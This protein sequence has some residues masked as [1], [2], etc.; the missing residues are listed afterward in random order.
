MYL[1]LLAHC[2]FFLNAY[3][4]SQ[5]AGEEVMLHSCMLHHCF[6]LWDH[7]LFW[8]IILCM[9]PIWSHCFSVL[10]SFLWLS[11]LFVTDPFCYLGFSVSYFKFSLTS[12]C[13]WSPSYSHTAHSNSL[14][15]FISARGDNPPKTE[16]SSTA[17][18]SS[19]GTI[20]II[21]TDGKYF[22]FIV[23]SLNVQSSCQLAIYYYF[24][25]STDL[26]KLI[27]YFR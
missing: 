17:S 9:F 23:L 25:H 7:D 6:H 21:S 18:L 5:S 4:A 20:T 1:L 26:N 27:F 13:Q 15:R 19:P 8:P 10:P 12:A 3:I 16:S 11:L 22:A 24:T 14:S 2:V